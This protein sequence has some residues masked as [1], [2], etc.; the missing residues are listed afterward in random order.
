MRKTQ[1]ILSEQTDHGVEETHPAFGVAVVTRG[2]GGEMS[3]FQSDLRHNEFITLSIRTADRTRDLNRDW[4]HPREE[5][6]EVRMS[7][8]Q[9][10]ALVSSVGIGSGVPVT[11][12][13]TTEDR[14]VPGIPFAPRIAASLGEVRGSVGKMLAKARASL[15]VLT[16]AIEQKKGVVATRNALRSHTI[17]LSQAEGNAEFAVTS[18]QEA[19]EDVVSQARVDIEAHILAAQQQTGLASPV[20][21]PTLTLEEG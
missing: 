15:E 11:I 10:G 12:T 21:A 16:E 7:M 14:M 18:L 1:P 20:I 19:A 4:V 9:W 13:S 2:H 17:A 8:A 3:L 6:V 5:L